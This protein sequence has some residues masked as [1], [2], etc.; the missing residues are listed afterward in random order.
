[1]S[2]VRRPRCASTTS[3]TAAAGEAAEATRAFAGGVVVSG[4]VRGGRLEAAAGP[5]AGASIPL[6]PDHGIPDAAAAVAVVAADEVVI[7]PA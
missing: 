6:P 2:V 3:R 4:I 5:L 1:M 7:R